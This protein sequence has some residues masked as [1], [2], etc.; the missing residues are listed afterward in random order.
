[1]TRR[2]AL[3]AVLAVLGIALSAALAWATS[4]L[5]GQ[6]IGLS[7]EPISMA[8]ALAPGPHPG[9]SGRGDDHSAPRPQASQTTTTS[10]QATVTST[11]TSVVTPAAGPATTATTAAPATTTAGSARSITSSSSGSGRHGDGGDRHDD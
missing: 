6:R 3:T 9:S 4:Q 1:M 8:G 11:T 5:A 2:T 7:G 10:Q